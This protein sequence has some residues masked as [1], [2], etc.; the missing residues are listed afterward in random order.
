MHPALSYKFVSVT[1]PAAI[2][3]NAAWTCAEIDT[4]GYD[5]LTVIAYLGATDI[6]MA[7]LQVT[8]ADVSATSHAAVTGLVY[9]TSTNIAGATSALPTADD[10]NK[11]FAFEVDLRGRKR[12]L[13]LG[14]TA[15]DGS[16]GS[17][18]AAFALLWKADQTPV[19][20]AARGFGDILR[21][22]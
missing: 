20:A 18:L 5:Y 15:G 12:Y 6:A 11:A 1:P 14:A 9:G 13:Q 7:A 17:F 2:K 4:Q 3:D 10:D 8:E 21:V 16:S 19:T 22:S